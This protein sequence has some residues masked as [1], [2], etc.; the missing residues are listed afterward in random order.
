MSRKTMS[1]GKLEDAVDLG[2][3]MG[4][5]QAFSLMA[6]RCSAADAECIRK[7]RGDRTYRA[8]GL[9]WDKF[10]RERLG[11]SRSTADS[12]VRQLEEFGPAFFT[13]AQVM[14]ITADEY[15]RIAS[16][17]SGGKLLHA[18]EEIPIEAENA[19]RLAVAIED[20]RRQ[21]KAEAAARPSTNHQA[22]DSQATGAGIDAVFE[23][24][25][26]ALEAVSQDLE[27]ACALPLDAARRA[28]LRT[29]L[30]RTINR[31]GELGFAIEL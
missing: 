24:I 1:G 29:L 23:K 4:R 9:N 19:P 17:V 16:A 3:W 20:L 5:K 30:L 27:H 21:R 26:G 18:G 8:L 2:T 11:I 10:C 13:L 7:M 31:L 28:N 12:I 22:M 6:G 14:H 25:E 15:R